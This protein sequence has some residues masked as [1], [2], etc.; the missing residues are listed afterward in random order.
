MT[1]NSVYRGAI[2]ALLFIG[3]VVAAFYLFLVQGSA[4]AVPTLSETAIQKEKQLVAA[5]DGERR[6]SSAWKATCATARWQGS[7]Q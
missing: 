3:L 5:V 1:K 4:S 2:V 6:S 7:R